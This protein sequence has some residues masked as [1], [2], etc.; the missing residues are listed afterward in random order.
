MK[1]WWLFLLKLVLTVACLWW[2]FS[3][4]DIR[5]TP[6][7]HPER[8]RW[9]WLAAGLVMAGATMVLS[10]MRWRIF[11]AAQEV[12]VSKGRALE[13]T[14]IGNLFAMM[15]VGGLAGDAARVLLLARDHPRRK[16]GVT[17]AVMADH[18]SGMVGLVLLFFLFTAGRFEDLGSPSALG[19]GVLHFAY[20]YLGG[21]LVLIVLGFVLM[22]PL[23][24]GRVHRG[25]RWIRWEF[26][27]TVPE[28]WDLFRQRWPHALGG[29]AV[30]CVML[31][32][33]FLTFW[34]GMQAAG[35]GVGA[36]TTLS[37]MPVIDAISSIP[38]SV[39]GIGVR[40]KLFVILFGDAAGI[41][42]DLAVAGSLAGFFCHVAWS[43]V[44]A[45]LFLLHH[46]EVTAR[47][48]EEY[49]G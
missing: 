26:M 5:S 3:G 43:L 23:V 22:S 12:R 31:L 35:C 24:H 20:V 36:G 1:K 40:E 8:L 19:T 38:V 44:G 33:H 25:G 37:A 7:W 2:A 34:C 6:L 42:A 15:S 45:V 49:H 27:R 17:V 39:S 21:G 46:G 18:M 48:I 32:A 41:D 11:L 10:A 29:L 16:L 28:A 13:L 30:S 47:E 14:L 4:T 9:D